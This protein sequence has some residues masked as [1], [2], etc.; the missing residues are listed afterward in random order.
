MLVK[1]KFG[2]AI[3]SSTLETT[4]GSNVQRLSWIIIVNL[5][6]FEC[7]KQG[8]FTVSVVYFNKPISAPAYGLY[9]SCI[10]I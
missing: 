2:I 3:K 6:I 8:G 4:N 7:F 1:N 5:G 9:W 10:I